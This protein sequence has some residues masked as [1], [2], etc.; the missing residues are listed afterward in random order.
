MPQTPIHQLLDLAAVHGFYLSLLEHVTGEAVPVPRGT[1]PAEREGTPVEQSVSILRRWLNILD[2][3]ISPP[4]FRDALKDTPDATTAESLLRYYVLKI[5]HNDVDR[6]KCDFINT[7]LYRN[8]RKSKGKSEA[9]A[10][11]LEIA[12]DETLAYEGEIYVML[13]EV[14]PPELPQE[15]MQLAREFDHLRLEVDEFLHFD[16]L[17]DSGIIG[18]VREIKHSF[19]TSFYHPHVLANVAL[20]NAFFGRKFDQLFAQAASEIKS[21][22][23]TVQQSGGSMQTR[24]NDEVTV[25]QLADVHDEEIHHEE[26]GK[27][28]DHLRKLAE[29]KRVVDIR[30]KGRYTAP[31][32][33]NAPAVAAA[34]GANVEPR[35]VVPISSYAGEAAAQPRVTTPPGVAPATELAPSHKAEDHKIDATSDMIR[36]F[37]LVADKSFANVVPLRNCSVLLT[38]AEVDAFRNAYLGEKSFRADYAAMVR[39]MAATMAAIMIELEDYQRKKNSAY[40]WK[41]HADSLKYF[42][43][44]TNRTIQAAK[45]M[46]AGCER[47]GLAEK[48]RVLDATADRLRN[49]AQQVAK[50]LQA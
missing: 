45:E 42:L 47:R 40:L 28:R 31:L 6:D 1:T 23:Q 5:S 20:Y 29:F 12:L 21:F 44:K 30:R 38:P 22:A 46:A 10:E 48:V 24:L 49:Q 14:E 39:Q 33:M 15:H 16:K 3:A 26:Y 17:M 41:Q 35:N 13:G 7:F 34:M 18:R 43:E 37:I 2:L 50:F 25:Q 36:N 32:P 27:A 4:M 11:A 8:W 9:P 19:A